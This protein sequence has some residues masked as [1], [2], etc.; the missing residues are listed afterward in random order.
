MP[1]IFGRGL[2]AFG[3]GGGG[4]AVCGAAASADIE[5]DGPCSGGMATIGRSGSSG[6]GGPGLECRWLR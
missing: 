5:E 4:A 1:R 2:S 3:D 6:E